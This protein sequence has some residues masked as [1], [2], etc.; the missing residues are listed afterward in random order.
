MFI[1]AVKLRNVLWKKIE[2]K[3]YH[4]PSNLLLHYLTESKMFNYAT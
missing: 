3:L 4:F 1:F 2:L